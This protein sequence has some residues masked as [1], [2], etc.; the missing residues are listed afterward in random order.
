MPVFC[1]ASG[2]AVYY[3][4]AGYV[5]DDYILYR[6]CCCSICIIPEIAISR[7]AA[8][9][10]A[11]WKTKADRGSIYFRAVCNV[12]SCAGLATEEEF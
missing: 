5:A 9:K 7:S 12:V 1:R 3:R 11:I 4:K 2:G 6:A 8:C 10:R